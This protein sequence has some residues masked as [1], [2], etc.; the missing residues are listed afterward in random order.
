MDELKRQA[1][2]AGFLYLLAVIVGPFRLIYIPNTLFVAGDATATAANIAAHAAMFRW[3]IVS[4]VVGSTIMLFVTLAL[5]RLFKGVD[6]T[7]AALMLILGGLMVTPL[8]FA[9]TVT[10]AAALQIASAPAY[11]T[12]AFSGPQRDA[13]VL[14]AIRMH[15]AC[16]VAQELFWGLWLLP[17]GMLVYRSRFIPRVLGVW[18]VLNCFAYVALCFTAL[19]VPQYE[20]TVFDWGQPAFFGEVA[21]MLWLLVAGARPRTLAS[22]RAD[23]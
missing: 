22:V 11:L 15:H 3:G 1:R 16:D 6:Q 12:A 19:I 8:Q 20:S 21:I 10:D 5:Y 13:L 9:N 17:F 18:L 7:L 14:L 2:L 4:E 23:V